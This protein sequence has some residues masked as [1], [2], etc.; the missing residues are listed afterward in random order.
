MES[1]TDR[2]SPPTHAGEKHSSN[3]NLLTLVRPP[4]IWLATGNSYGS[5]EEQS[6]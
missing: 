5:E 6:L 3:F 1:F 4:N 2:L